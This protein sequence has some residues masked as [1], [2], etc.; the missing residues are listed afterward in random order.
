MD[1][2]NL[3]L[4]QAVWVQDAL[5]A[6]HQGFDAD[7]F[8]ATHKTRHQDTAREAYRAAL[9]LAREEGGY[10][11]TAHYLSNLLGMLS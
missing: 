9:A 3:D 11:R 5:L 7:E 1:I 10:R 8:A 4:D 6:A 2:H